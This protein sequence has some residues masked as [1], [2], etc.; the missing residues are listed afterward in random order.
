MMFRAIGKHVPKPAR[1]SMAALLNPHFTAFA[2]RLLGP[3]GRTFSPLFRNTVTPTFL[4]GGGQ[5]NV[6]P[7]EVSVDLDGRLL[8]GLDPEQLIAEMMELAGARVKSRC[9]VTTQG[10]SGPTWACPTL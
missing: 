9:C 4:R 6:V 10:R 3:R 8:P 7:D 5:I 2:L 1:A